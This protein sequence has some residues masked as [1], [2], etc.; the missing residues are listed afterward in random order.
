MS[1]PLFPILGTKIPPMLGRSGSMQRIWN[2]LTKPTPSNLSIIGPRYVGKTVI[3]HAL[4]HRALRETSPYEFVLYWH[5]GHLPPQSDQDFIVQLCG[6]LRDSL[7]Q[8]QADTAEYRQH[9]SEHSFS[10]LSEVAEYLDAE[11]RPIL[12]LWD[13]FDKPLGQ[14]RLTINLWDQMRTLFYG[15][16]HKIVTALRKPLSQLI[17]SLDNSPFWNIFDMN[18][19]RVGA[20]DEQDR[21]TILG[22]LPKHSFQKGAKTELDNWTAGVPPLFL[23]VL[24]EIIIDIPS[25]PVDNE[26]VN[27]A[28]N[29]A[30]QNL[31]DVIGATWQDCPAGAKDLYIH[32]V[33]R[34]DLIISEAGKQECGCLIEMGFARQVGNKLTAS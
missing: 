14:G 15:R 29:N 33:E 4:A 34:G 25:G 3:M 1:E 5:L 6:K 22:M 23:E 12:M 16:K 7:A 32:L 28:A 18:P 31:T 10:N 19:V 13:G 27:R 26:S 11:G 24:N 8:S 30:L 9:L 20:F 21:E 17:R 2:D